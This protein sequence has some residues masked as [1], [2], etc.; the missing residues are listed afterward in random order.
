METKSIH[1]DDYKYLILRLRN[2]REEKGITQEVLAQMFGCKQTVISKIESCERR[3]DIIEL[4]EILKL[5]D[6]SFIDFIADI[7][8]ELSK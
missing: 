1:T 5:L 6:I 8:K 7:D 3:I 2:A 4:R